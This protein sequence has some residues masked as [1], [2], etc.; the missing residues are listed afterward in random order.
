MLSLLRWP[1]RNPGSS[2]AV[3]HLAEMQEEESLAFP[4]SLQRDDREVSAILNT[5]RL[6]F[7]ARR[8]SLRSEIATLQEGINALQ[9][10]IEGGELQLKYVEE[11]L[12]LFKEEL[13]SKSQLETRGLVKKSE[14]LALKRAEANMKGEIGRLNGEIGDAKERIARISEQIMA[15]RN[16]AIRKAVE[17]LH[18]S[19]AELNDF[20]ERVRAARAVL[21]RVSIVAPVR[22]VVVKLRYN[23]PGG[24]IEPG[25]NIMEILPL[26]EELVIEARIRLQDIDNVKLG[27]DAEVRL[28]AL[29]RRVTPMI[30]GKVIY[31]SADSLAD[32][33]NPQGAE[34]I[35][36]VRVKLDR[37]EAAQVQA[38][39]PTPGMP[40]EVFVKTAERTFFEYLV[41]PIEDSMSRAFRES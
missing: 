7:E 10:R 11:Q 33:T 30:K 34:D 12:D 39:S 3:L 26:G 38:F 37:A 36:I 31:V 19:S 8:R 18:E 27:Q 32:S 16:A 14:V 29:S 35:Y 28:T 15:M 23:T 6:T 9:R 21:A 5:Q 1:S 22:G 4:D 24:V 41:K 25:K 17:E 2:S 20:N 40:V 13:A